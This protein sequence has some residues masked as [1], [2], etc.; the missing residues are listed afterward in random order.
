M[1]IK[2]IWGGSVETDI[3]SL[4]VHMATLRR[5]LSDTTRP[6]PLIRTHVGIGYSMNRL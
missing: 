3:V 1:I 6:E 5:K 4:R 2:E